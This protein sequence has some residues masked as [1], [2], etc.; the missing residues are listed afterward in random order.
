MNILVTGGSGF[1]GSHV[2]ELLIKKKHKAIIIDDLSSGSLDNL[3]NLN[4]SDYKFYNSRLEDFNLED[5]NEIDGVIHLAA[6]ASVPYSISNFYKSSETNLLSSLKIIDYC[7]NKDIPLIY[8]SSSAIYGSLDY[9]NDKTSDIDLISPYAADKYSL[10]VYTKMAHT[11]YGLSSI[12]LRFFNVYGPRQDPSN[13][14]SGVISIFIDRLLLKKDIQINGGK[15]TR[16]FI[17]VSDIADSIYKALIC[18]KE[19]KMN[20]TI[21]VLTGKSISID[22]LADILIKALSPSSKKKYCEYIA[23]DPLKS[24]GSINRLTCD[25]EMDISRFIQLE[26][27]LKKTIQSYE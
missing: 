27:G 14:Y 22:Y 2:C 21:N 1:I 10:E 26:E 15:Q 8:A 4:N 13:P 11:V 16:D 19:K 9:G 17:Y 18:C 5:L 12:G 7:S 6:Q 23:G 3:L 20:S 24:E 25:L